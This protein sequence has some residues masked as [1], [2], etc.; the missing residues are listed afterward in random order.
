M[1]RVV[2]AIAIAAFAL[3]APAQVYK[4]RDAAGNIQYGDHPPSGIDAERVGGRRGAAVQSQ[5][6]EGAGP[7]GAAA[8]AAP[9]Q[10]TTAQMVQDSRKREQEAEAKRKKDEAAAQ[11]AKAAEDNCRR[12][13]QNVATLDAG[14]RQ[15]RVDDK[16][17]RIFL[18][19]A[20][21][22][23]ER[24]EAQRSVSEWCK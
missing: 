21:I 6:T 12:A 2:F 17:E 8:P 24:A 15:A 16:G 7:S 3:A 1:R 9:A 18:D 22:A 13:R 14:G 19:D 20:Q 5:S 4:W 10:K 23:K 11:K